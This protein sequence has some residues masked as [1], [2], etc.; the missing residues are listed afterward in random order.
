M[1]KDELEKYSAGNTLPMHMP[2]HKRNIAAFP[3]LAPLGGALDITE[4][5]GFDDLNA[6]ESFFASLERRASALRGADETVCLVNGSTSAVLAAVTSALSRGGALLMCRASHKSL[7]HAAELSRSPVYYLEPRMCA[8][9]GV[10]AS[11]TAGEVAC[12]LDLHPDVRLAAVT[13]P[14]YEGVISDIK[15]IASVCHE[16][17]VTLFVDG[18]HGAHLGL[19]GFPK[20][21]VTEGADL[22]AESLHKTLPSLTQTALL[23]INHGFADSAD[24]RRR[25]A[26]FQSSS[27]SYILSASIDGCVLYLEREGEAAASRWLKSLRRFEDASR[28]LSHLR[29]FTGG[30]GVFA[31]DP[32]KLLF[33]AAGTDLSGSDLMRILR[34]KYHI[35]PE[36]A[37][38]DNV[39]AMTGMGDTE[40]SLA[41]FF[42]AIEEIDR[43]C[44]T[45][46]SEAV[47]PP[48]IPERCIFAYEAAVRECEPVPLCEAVGRISAEYVWAY[49]PGI[50]YLVPGEVIDDA[51]MR[52][53]SSQ[54]K[55][56]STRKRLPIE[57]FC[58]T[59][60]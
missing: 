1:L 40:D 22:V 23:H 27:P 2:G 8:G 38:G 49:P 31:R 46:K 51:L 48:R 59:S 17:G 14:T 32:S 24:V 6:P 60:V 52:M 15:G 7:Y 33:S 12:A 41:R 36:M 35:E 19:G 58:L 44:R 50:P 37:C 47:S 53:I 34:T 13:S 56:H 29:L 54:D 4:I 26:I 5:D 20:S 39:L 25:A 3:W 30:E 43:S 10:P 18:A 55:L 9:F 11:V 57:I 16:R 42:H 45:G 21:A 28:A